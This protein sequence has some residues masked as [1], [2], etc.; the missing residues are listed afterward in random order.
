MQNYFV[1]QKMILIE[2]S[3]DLKL[4]YNVVKLPYNFH[5]RVLIENQLNPLAMQYHSKLC[6]LLCIN[7][8]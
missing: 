3:F 8:L 7:N 5:H 6:I 1:L 2:I 4:Y